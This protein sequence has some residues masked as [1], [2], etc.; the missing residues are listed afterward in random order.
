MLWNTLIH[1]TF[2][3]SNCDKKFRAD[4]NILR[5]RIAKS[6]TKVHIRGPENH[7]RMTYIQVQKCAIT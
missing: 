7:V 6:V 2:I 3:K 4:S 1:P 5:A